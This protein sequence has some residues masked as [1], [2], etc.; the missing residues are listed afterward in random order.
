MANSSSLKYN[1]PLDSISY[2]VYNLIVIFKLKDYY[3]NN[4]KYLETYKSN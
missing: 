4:K 1:C 2:I 3:K